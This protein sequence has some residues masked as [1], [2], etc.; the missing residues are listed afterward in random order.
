MSNNFSK[1]M[2]FSYLL[3]LYG[4]SACDATLHL[5]CAT[6]VS[7]KC[8]H[9]PKFDEIDARNVAQAESDSASAIMR[10]TISIM[11]TRC[12]SVARNTVKTR[13]R[14]YT[15]LQFR[16]IL[17]LYIRGFLQNQ[18]EDVLKVFLNLFLEIIYCID[19]QQ[20]KLMCNHNVSLN[21]LMMY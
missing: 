9:T 18:P 10:A 12:Y 4:L 2:R 15:F 11:A 16:L 19:Y 20:L 8:G 6:I 1:C 3:E 14:E 21:D 13:E 5:Y 17:F 7:I